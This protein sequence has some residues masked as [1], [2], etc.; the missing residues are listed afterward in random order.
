MYIIQDAYDL[1]T[2]IQLVCEAILSTSS[3]PFGQKPTGILSFTQ[4][5]GWPVPQAVG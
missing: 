1:S 3:P 2:G 5:E 4:K